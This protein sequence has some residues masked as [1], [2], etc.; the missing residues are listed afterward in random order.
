M[1]P[2]LYLGISAQHLATPPDVIF[3]AGDRK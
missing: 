1:V 2:S 3:E